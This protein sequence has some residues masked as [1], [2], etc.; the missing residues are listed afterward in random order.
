MIIHTRTPA[1]VGLVGN[2]SDGFNGV[3]ISFTFDAFWA[4][5]ALWESP[6]LEIRLTPQDA[7]C[8]ASIDDLVHN[9]SNYGY[10]GGIRLIKAIIKV[11]ADYCREQGIELDRRNFTV[12][13]RSAIPLRVG[14]A[15]SSAIITSALRA[16]M[17]FYGVS[18]PKPIM[19]NLILKA[20][21]QELKIGAGLQDRVVQVYGGLVYMDFNRELMARGYGHYE[22]LDPRML[23]PLY[24]AYDDSST[25]GT[26][27]FHNDVRERYA[28][29]EK[30]VI[31]TM[32]AIAENARHFR[33]AMEAGDLDEM[34]RCINRNFDLRSRIYRI[35]DLN[36][37]LIRTARDLGASSKF[38]GSGGAV[39]GI[40]RD[41]EAFRRLQEAYRAIGATILR[42]RVVS[43]ED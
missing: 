30:L 33:Q 42:P 4:E 41:D 27:V 22:N 29:G 3:T 2:P 8:F 15:G 11:F 39:V 37:R 10:Y 32:D 7:T 16:L 28:R 23:P 26:E 9:V 12:S 17:Q 19:P 24:V 36:R 18:I 31:E 1:R 35:N 25:E 40:C 14:L 5:V 20:E 38:C 21:T 6:E 43:Y 34:D 13:Y